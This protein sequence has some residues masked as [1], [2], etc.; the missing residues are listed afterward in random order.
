MRKKVLLAIAMIATMVGAIATVT[1][2]VP[3]PEQAKAYHSTGC[4]DLWRHSGHLDNVRWY[5]CHNVTYDGSRKW[6][7]VHICRWTGW[8]HGISVYTYPGYVYTWDH[9]H[10]YD[11]EN[12][13]SPVL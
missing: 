7:R 9:A 2:V 5:H 13:D 8:L 3:E 11:G 6:G 1:L 10:D 4:Y 12:C